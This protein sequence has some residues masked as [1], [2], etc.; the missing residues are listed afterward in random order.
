MPSA[1]RGADVDLDLLVGEHAVLIAIGGIEIL[2]ESVDV[3]LQG[4]PAVTIPVGR[5]EA[6]GAQLGQLRDD[7]VAVLVAIA[8]KNA[9]TITR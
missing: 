1:A 5:A 6:L 7:Q 3:F 2:E 4:E 8:K 9:S